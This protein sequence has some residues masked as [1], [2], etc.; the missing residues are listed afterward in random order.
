[1]VQ[2]LALDPNLRVRSWRIH[3]DLTSQDIRSKLL[4]IRQ[5]PL[6]NI[7]LMG[8]HDRDATSRVL[9]EVGGASGEVRKRHHI[10]FK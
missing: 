3:P 1:M 2:Q 7:I 9:S 6:T 5:L 8:D 10:I 4:Y